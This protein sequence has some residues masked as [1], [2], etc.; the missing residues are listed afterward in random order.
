VVRGGVPACAGMTEKRLVRR[1][2][3]GPRFRGDDRKE[4]GAKGGEWKSA[5]RVMNAAN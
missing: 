1:K 4:V 3:S 5:S 2:V